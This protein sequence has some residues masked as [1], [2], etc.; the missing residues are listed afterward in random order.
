MLYGIL[1][2]SVKKVSLVFPD[3]QHHIEVRKVMDGMGDNL[4]VFEQWLS[5][6]A[7][8]HLKDT[9]ESE[10]HISGH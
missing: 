10:K 4:D 6:D 7:E 1:F 3:S 9:D 5:S 2:L 8:Q